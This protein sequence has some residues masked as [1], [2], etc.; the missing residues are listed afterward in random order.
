[1]YEIF[2]QL[3]NKYNV[4]PYRVGRETGIAGSTF[5]AWKNGI[6]S[7]KPEKLQKIADYFGVSIDYLMGRNH[8]EKTSSAIT[9]E[10]LNRLKTLKINDKLRILFDETQEL[11]PSDIDFVLEMVNKLK[12]R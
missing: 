7:P 2:E 3:L 10:D 6:S 11:K 8:D 4:T 1:M 5:T 12:N 9:E